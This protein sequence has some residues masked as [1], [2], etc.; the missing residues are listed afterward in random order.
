MLK[1]LAKL[2]KA[3]SSNNDPGAIAC[4]FSFGIL[5]GFMPKVSALWFVLFVFV[6]FMRIQRGAFTLSIILGVIIAPLLDPLFDSVGMYILTLPQYRNT[7]IKLLD[8]PFV[9]FTRFNNTVV[10][11]SLA[12]G[13]IAIIPLYFVGRGFIFVWRRFIGESLRKF[14]FIQMIKQIPLIEKIASIASGEM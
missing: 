12:C 1:A 10:M 6:L 4:A 2:I 14:K 13:L 11:G 3:L 8:I 7:Y 9:A 5:L